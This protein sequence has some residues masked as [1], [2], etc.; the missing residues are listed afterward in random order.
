MNHWSEWVEIERA[1]SG[2][3]RFAHFGIYHIRAVNQSGSPITVGRLAGI[4]RAGILY[5]GRSGFRWQKTQRTLGNRIDEWLK[6]GHSGGFRFQGLKP[7]L[8]S[9]PAF[10]GHRLQ[11]RA[12]VLP[13]IEIEKAEVVSLQ[14]YLSLYAELPPINS[15]MPSAK[16]LP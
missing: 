8:D 11:A 6:G 7:A 10:R 1:R 12:K 9:S 14:D 13:D 5:I 2:E 4:D 15:S 3:G 16:S